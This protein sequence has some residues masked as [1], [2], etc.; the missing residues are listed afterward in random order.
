MFALLITLCY[1]K[2]KFRTKIE[3]IYRTYSAGDTPAP[4][5]SPGAHGHHVGDYWCAQKIEPLYFKRPRENPVFHDI[6]PLKH[7]HGEEE[8][9]VVV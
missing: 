2:I 1:E 3:A 8:Q 6:T 7:T 4:C 5:W 9:I